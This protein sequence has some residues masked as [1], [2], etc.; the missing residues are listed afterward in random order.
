MGMK[1]E[2]AKAESR[3]RLIYTKFGP[4]QKP[5]PD[6]SSNTHASMSNKASN[7]L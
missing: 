4:K 7:F 3:R 6:Q 1:D 2:Q 5:K